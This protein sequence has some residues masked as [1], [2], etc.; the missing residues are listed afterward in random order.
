MFRIIVAKADWVDNGCSLIVFWWRK[1][2]SWLHKFRNLSITFYRGCILPG[3]YEKRKVKTSTFF[4]K[5]LYFARDFL[6]K[7]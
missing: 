4:E 7:I 3:A 6:K 1:V 2:Y 5:L